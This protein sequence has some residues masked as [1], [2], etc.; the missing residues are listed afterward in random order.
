M[1]GEKIP[2]TTLVRKIVSSLLDKFSSKVI[3]IEEAR[4][5]DS[6]KVEDLMGPLSAFEMTLSQR[7]REKSIALKTVHKEED[8]SREDNEDELALLTKNFKKFLMKVAKSSKFGSSFPNM[9]KGKNFFTPKNSDFSN[10]K[11]RIQCRGI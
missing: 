5:L 6:M 2:E 4:D 3:D 11:K 1:F 7:K 10:N 9:F 8:S